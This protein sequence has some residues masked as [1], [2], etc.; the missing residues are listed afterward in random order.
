MGRRACEAFEATR[1][2]SRARRS[3]LSSSQGMY[4]RRL[5]S[6]GS[7]IAEAECSLLRAHGSVMSVLIRYET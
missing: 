7:R 6:C 2:N 1:L 3:V 5:V 4:V